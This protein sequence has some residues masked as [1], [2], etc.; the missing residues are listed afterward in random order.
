MKLSELHTLLQNSI[1]TSEPL[2]NPH[3][4]APPKGSVADRVAIYA[5]GFYG[6]LEEA[7]MSDYSSLAEL[8]GEDKFSEMSR[9]YTHS[10]PSYNYSLN[11]FGE[12]LS[13][14]LTEMLP[15][16]KKPYLAEIAA[17]EWA[18]YQ[19][20]VAQDANLLSVAD[21]QSLPLNQWPEM[22][23]HLHPSCKIVAM[24]W[25]SL[26]L[27]N[28]LRSNKPIP[29]P[30]K[31]TTPKYV[32]VWRR[33]LDVRYRT[34]EPLELT[35]LNAIIQGSSFVNI[36]E[37]LSHHLPEDEVASYLVSEL[38]AWI[39]EHCFINKAIAIDL[40]VNPAH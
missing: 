22:K 32:M 20:V 1:L 23:F 21:L 18:E 26:S 10:Y 12:N 37:I 5:N 40:T 31:L 8:M 16:K 11:N 33:Q 25:N 15:Y 35:M 7:L 29:K 34:L 4:D 13:Q 38:H 36:C 17:F 9:R 30:K 19:A 24:Y 27:I 3:L 6:R 28:A 2:I 39:Q 14:L